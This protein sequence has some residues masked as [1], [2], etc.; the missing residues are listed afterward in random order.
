MKLGD[1]IYQAKQKVLD[2]LSDGIKESIREE[3]IR[4]ESVRSEWTWNDPSYQV[5]YLHVDLTKPY[6][7]SLWD[8]FVTK[9]GL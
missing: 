7:P 3:C 2:D 5:Y 4:A 9:L 8:T 6:Q 1:E